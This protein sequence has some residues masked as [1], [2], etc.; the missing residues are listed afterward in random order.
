[1]SSPKKRRVHVYVEDAEA[2]MAYGRLHN[3][4]GKNSHVTYA[5]II[6]KKLQEEWQT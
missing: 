5:E 6:K 2:L 1:M 4:R 3:V